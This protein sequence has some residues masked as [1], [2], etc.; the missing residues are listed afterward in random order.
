[1]YADFLWGLSNG[2]SVALG[3]GVRHYTD[4]LSFFKPTAVSVVPSL[5]KLFDRINAFNPEL[6]IVLTGAGDCSPDLMESVKAKL[7]DA[8]FAF[9][10]GLTETSSGVAISVGTGDPYALSICPDDTITIAKDGEIL[11]ESPT[12]MMKGYY[13]DPEGTA[14]VLRDGV[15]YTG[16]LGLFDPAGKLHI[17]GRKKEMLVLPDGMKI[18]LP[19]YEARL[20]ELLGTAEL[21]VTLKGNRPVLIIQTAMTDAQIF[22]TIRPFTDELPRSQQLSEIILT[23]EPLPRTATGKV[24]RWQLREFV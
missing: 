6:R 22:D 24:Q 11:I 19:E 13:N 3:R 15:L 4:D 18:F 12:C 2:A 8:I 9:G 16:D 14:E 21:A 20:S 23:D 1:L 17:T 7:P 5:L 10:Y